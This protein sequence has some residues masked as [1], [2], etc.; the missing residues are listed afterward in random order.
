MEG[1]FFVDCLQD[2]LSFG[3]SETLHDMGFNLKIGQKPE[4]RELTDD[5][6]LKALELGRGLYAETARVITKIYGISYT[7]AGVRDRVLRSF[8]Q[9]AEE[10]KE[11]LLDQAENTVVD[12][13][14][15]RMP[16]R[17]R[18]QA[19]TWYLRKQGK[20]R[21][22]ADQLDLNLS[23]SINVVVADD[24]VPDHIKDEIDS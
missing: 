9:E 18:L 12:L 10:I 21:G 20:E 19:A 24:P 7:R 2:F 11:A 4:K 14:S 13:M 16:A 6:F 15:K 8:K 22:Y 3:V 1:G 5:E 23:K 17:V